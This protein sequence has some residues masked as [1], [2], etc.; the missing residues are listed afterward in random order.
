MAF[1]GILIKASQV[2]YVEADSEE[3]AIEVGIDNYSPS[4]FEFDEGRCGEK[5][6]SDPG[7]V[8]GK[9]IYK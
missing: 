2:V 3:E 7:E 9:V 6:D 1:Y 5:F 8:Y 4:D